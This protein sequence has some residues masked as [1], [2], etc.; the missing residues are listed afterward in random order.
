ML[1]CT[2][3]RPRPPSPM[4]R[5]RSA[6][7]AQRFPVRRSPRA[8]LLLGEVFST[9]AEAESANPAFVPQFLG[10][11]NPRLAAFVRDVISAPAWGE[12][13][14]AA[15]A[16]RHALLPEG[17]VEAVN[18]WAYAKY[19]AALLDLNDGYAVNPTIV[20]ELT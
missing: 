15:L 19:D 7:P 3:G 10:G 20:A 18:E 2:A 16:A 14:I 8:A 17:A 12:S 6:Q 5:Y 13:A 11:L 1:I 9:E 4:N